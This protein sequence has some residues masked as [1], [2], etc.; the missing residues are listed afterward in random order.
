MWSTPVPNE[1]ISF[2][3]GPACDSTRLSMRSVTV[4][5]STSAA[6]TASTSCGEPS[7][8]SSELS[9]VSNNSINRV[10][11]ASGSFRV[12]IT[13]G[14][15]LGLGGM[16]D[17]DRLARRGVS[18]ISNS[19]SAL[20][21]NPGPR[22]RLRKIPSY[23]RLVARPADLRYTGLDG[24]TTIPVA[25]ALLRRPGSRLPAAVAL[26]SCRGACRR[27]VGQRP[28]T[29]GLGPAAPALRL[30]AVGR[31]QRANRPRLALPRRLGLQAQR[32]ARRDRGR[33]REL[34]ENPRLAGG[35]RLGLPQSAERQALLHRPGQDRQPAQ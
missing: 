27:Q 11:M 25:F 19:P 30:V 26:Q 20:S 18:P 24:N 32:H 7:G 33:I 1:A 4:G 21:S 31:G 3:R 8:L 29:Q 22:A 28:A 2:R 14:F 35:E 10:S 13:S 34:A 17:R 16:G 23:Q 12:T 6:F 9:R 5:T 15:F